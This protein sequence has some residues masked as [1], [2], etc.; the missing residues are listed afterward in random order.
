M[1][2]QYDAEA[3]IVRIVFRDVFVE[4]TAEEIPGIVI[5]FDQDGVVVGIEILKASQQIDHPRSFQ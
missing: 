4:E 2:V 3:D 5:N 1:K